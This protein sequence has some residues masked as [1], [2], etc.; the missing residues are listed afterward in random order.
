M[1]KNTI[2]PIVGQSFLHTQIRSLQQLVFAVALGLFSS[3]LLAQEST[4][5]DSEKININNASAETLQY[6]PGIGA[7]KAE[8]IVKLRKQ[9][10]GFKSLE[11]LLEVRGIGEKLLESI[12]EYGT[13]DGGVSE[14][15]QEMMEN[16]P[17]KKMSSSNTTLQDPSS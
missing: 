17:S 7:S 9:K 16:P 15:T 2:Q 8:S 11:E 1:Y 13:L 4:Q 12:I 6:I 3:I 10:G 14:L 5:S